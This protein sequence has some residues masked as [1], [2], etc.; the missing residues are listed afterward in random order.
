MTDYIPSYSDSLRADIQP[1]YTDSLYHHGILGMHWGVRRFQNADGSLTAAGKSRYSWNP[2][3]R[4]K[5]KQADKKLNVEARKSFDDI[6]NK[7]VKMGSE[8]KKLELDNQWPYSDKEYERDK[9]WDKYEDNPTQANG[10]ALSRKAREFG[11]EYGEKTGKTLV[12]KYGN[13]AV[14]RYIDIQKREGTARTSIDDQGA[15]NALKSLQSRNAVER[16]AQYC[17]DKEEEAT[18]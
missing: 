16:Y 8:A 4:F 14:N 9:A 6:H 3:E 12:N 17:A 15:S 5:Q 1:S 2:I 11:Y 13:E 18:W 7:A 10:E